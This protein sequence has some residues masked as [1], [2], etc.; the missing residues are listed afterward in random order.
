MSSEANG[1]VAKK[2]LGGKAN[3][4]VALKKILVAKQTEW[5]LKRETCG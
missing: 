3:G 2:D 1:M 4:M 5:W